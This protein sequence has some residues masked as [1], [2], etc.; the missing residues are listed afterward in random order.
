MDLLPEAKILAA[1]YTPNAKDTGG[2][3][4]KEAQARAAEAVAK[5][6]GVNIYDIQPQMWTY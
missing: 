6:K 3:G 2:K 1:A 5:K 4:N